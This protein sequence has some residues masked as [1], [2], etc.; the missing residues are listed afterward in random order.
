M[1]G[2][3]KETPSG[4]LLDALIKYDYRG[5][6]HHEV[7]DLNLSGV[8]IMAKDGTLSRLDTHTPV[9]VALKMHT[10]GKTKVHVFRAH[11][12]HADRNGA[13]VEFS[14]ADI[15]AYSALLHLGNNHKG[16]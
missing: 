4:I 7:S 5:F 15:D 14:D 6:Q 13:Q 8:F 10:S 12:T 9:E 1:K 3:N 2:S 16:G 11:V